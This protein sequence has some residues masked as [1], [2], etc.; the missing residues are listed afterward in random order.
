M[1]ETKKDQSVATPEELQAL[2]AFPFVGLE[3]R[4]RHGDRLWLVIDTDRAYPWALE[5]IQGGEPPYL[6]PGQ[7]QFHTHQELW[8]E[9]QAKNDH[10]E[11]PAE[12][13]EDRAKLLDLARLYF[14]KAIHMALKERPIGIHLLD[15]G[16]HWKY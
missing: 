3:K 5:K 1:V 12:F 15:L 11:V 9:M 14:T 7:R 6:I 4:D 10:A 8:K 13:L 2:K 16:N